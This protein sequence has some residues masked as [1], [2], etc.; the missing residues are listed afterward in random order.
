MGKTKTFLSPASLE[1]A[2]SA[3][4]EKD[5]LSGWYLKGA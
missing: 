5:L 2:E 1:A 3:E 4:K